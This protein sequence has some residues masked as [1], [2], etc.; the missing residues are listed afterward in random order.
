VVQA[1]QVEAY[2]TCEA[3]RRA[4]ERYAGVWV[5]RDRSFARGLSSGNGATVKCHEVLRLRAMLSGGFRAMLSGGLTGQ[6]FG[7]FL[8]AV[9]V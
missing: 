2:M 1:W 3:W 7:V 9:E 6:L 8:K 5:M 4:S